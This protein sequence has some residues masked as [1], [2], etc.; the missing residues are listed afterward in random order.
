MRT[1]K[2]LICLLLLAFTARAQQ[3]TATN[4]AQ[5]ATGQPL[6]TTEFY[7]HFVLTPDPT[8]APAG[9]GL[10]PGQPITIGAYEASLTDQKKINFEMGRF[11]KT[12]LWD[13][14]AP[15]IFIS[16]ETAMVDNV[17]IEK[18]RVTKEGGK[19]T[20]TLYADL[21]KSGPVHAPKGFKFFTREQLAA[22][23]APL[24]TQ[25]KAFNAVAD[26]YGDA[27][28]KKT[29]FQILGYLQNNVGIDYLMDNDYLAPVFSDMGLDLD[30]RAYLIRSYM[31]H[32]FEYEATGHADP[33]KDAFNAV[34]DDYKDVIAKHEFSMQGSL[35]TTMVKK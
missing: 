10:T 26:K 32:K 29:G 4:A 28:N 18:F 22:A 33:K 24:L 17:N 20:V 25:L 30:L 6:P 3:N 9:Y 16:R 1:E 7:E 21:Y 35:A 23:V 31:F 2:L 13:D 8:P 34:V 14:G 27:E 5:P 19:D 12:F 15:I 11:Y